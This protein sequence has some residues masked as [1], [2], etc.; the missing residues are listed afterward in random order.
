MIQCTT[1]PWDQTPTLLRAM[2]YPPPRPRYLRPML[3]NPAMAYA[4]R[5][6]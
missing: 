6:R 4:V 2:A 3:A 5:D 1:I